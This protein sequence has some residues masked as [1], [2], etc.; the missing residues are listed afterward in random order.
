VRGLAGE[1][2]APSRDLADFVGQLDKPRA[3]WSCSGRRDHPSTGGR[4]ADLLQPGDT[5]IDAATPSS[6]TMSATPRC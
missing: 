5:L 2:A 6:R 4:L 3:V 1:G